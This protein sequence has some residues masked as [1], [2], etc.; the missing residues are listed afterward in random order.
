MNAARV[1]RSTARTDRA[2]HLHRLVIRPCKPS[3]P[4]EEGR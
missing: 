1:S 2:P 4:P 3:T